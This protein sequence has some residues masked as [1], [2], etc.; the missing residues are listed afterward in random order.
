M[1]VLEKIYTPRFETDMSLPVGSFWKHQVYHDQP[2]D[3]YFFT[4]R[5]GEDYYIFRYGNE[6]SENGTGP[7]S[8]LP[9]SYGFSKDTPHEQQIRTYDQMIHLTQSYLEWKGIRPCQDQ[10]WRDMYKEKREAKELALQPTY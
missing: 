10:E 4:D 6:C 8:R 9:H 1:D 2:C 3:I 5:N 7:C